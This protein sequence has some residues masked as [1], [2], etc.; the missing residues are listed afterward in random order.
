MK[1][2][3]TFLVSPHKVFESLNS[4]SR[5]FVPF[6]VVVV[7]MVILTWLTS[8]WKNQSVYFQMDA[9][10]ITLISFTLILFLSWS[11]ISVFLYL[12]A[13]LIEAN[14]IIVYKRIFSVVS[15]CG[16]IFLVGE[17]INFLLIFTK[18]FN[19]SLFVLHNR[20]PMG[21]DILAVGRSPH[22]ALAILLY[23]IN[24]FT[25]WYFTVLSI[26]FSTITGL[27]KIKARIFSFLV[28]LF[29]VGFIISLL[30][31]TGGTR[32]NIKVGA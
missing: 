26:G 15:F 27:T 30:L 3:F 24:P 18:A 12:A 10:L 4:K 29:I 5:W 11:F 14:S 21:L 31:I 1:T 16:I 9:V 25:V 22:P 6:S 28:W 7:G 32:I 20:F 13:S 23:S 17:V 19:D 2:L 8:C